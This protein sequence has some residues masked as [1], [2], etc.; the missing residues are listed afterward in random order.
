MTRVQGKRTAV[1]SN[2]FRTKEQTRHCRIN[3]VPNTFSTS[4]PLP[5]ECVNHGINKWYPSERSA[6]SRA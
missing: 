6:L 3:E 4:L 5:P 1:E 2:G